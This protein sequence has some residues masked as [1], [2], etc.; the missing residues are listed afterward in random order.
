MW[1]RQWQWTF[2]SLVRNIGEQFFAKKENG[3]EV[4]IFANPVTLQLVLSHFGDALLTKSSKKI[5]K[6]IV[7]KLTGIKNYD[8][9]KEQIK[10]MID[11]IHFSSMD[12]FKER[13]SKISLDY[14][15]VPSTNFLIFL[16]RFES[17][18]AGWIDAINNLKKDI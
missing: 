17:E 2:L 10:E 6:E 1:C 13:I 5:N 8:A 16:K 12:V 15:V 3:I 14:N 18:D 11:K 7:E 9:K 4:F